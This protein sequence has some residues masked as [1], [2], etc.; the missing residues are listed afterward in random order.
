MKGSQAARLGKCKSHLVPP[1]PAAEVFL[2]GRVAREGKTCLLVVHPILIT[3]LVNFSSF[4]WAFA[5][6]RPLESRRNSSVLGPV[7]PYSIVSR[8]LSHLSNSVSP[9]PKTVYSPRGA[10]GLEHL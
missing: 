1:N 3:V 5:T 6:H 8:P 10:L 7:S 4:G 9:R 2:V